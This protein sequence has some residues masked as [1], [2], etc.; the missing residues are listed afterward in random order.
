MNTNLAK[1]EKKLLKEIREYT[2]NNKELLNAH[3]F[4]FAC[5]VNKNDKPADI[6]ICGINPGGDPKGKD[7]RKIYKGR[8]FPT[9][10]SSDYDWWVEDHNKTRS[11]NGT[12][13]RYLKCAY[14]VLGSQKNIMLT[15]AFFWNSTSVSKKHFDERYGYSLDKNPHWDFCVKMNLELFKAHNPDL[16]LVFKSN[17]AEVPKIAK[18]FNLNEIHSFELDCGDRPPTRMYHYETGDSTP[19]IFVPHPSGYIWTSEMVKAIK[20]YLYKIGGV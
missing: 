5:P 6:I 3:H 15:E 19:F 18:R 11:S 17:K 2:F 1:I 4:L 13:G 9:E 10:E 14:D 7:Y 20:D 12:D 8:P 16:I